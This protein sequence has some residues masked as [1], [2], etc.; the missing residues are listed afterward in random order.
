M[1][2]QARWTVDRPRSTCVVNLTVHPNLRIVLGEGLATPDDLLSASLAASATLRMARFARRARLDIRAVQVEVSHARSQSG[3]LLT[4][5][6]LAVGS[7]TNRQ[8]LSLLRVADRC[9]V[10]KALT[11]RFRVVIL[12]RFRSA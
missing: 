7:L 12:E 3:R 1:V 5:A 4:M 10:H 2:I 9:P 6:I 11:G 8:Q